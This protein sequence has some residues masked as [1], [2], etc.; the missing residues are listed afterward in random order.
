MN[1]H[2]RH[3]LVVLVLVGYLAAC[4]SSGSLEAQGAQP[5]LFRSRRW[6]DS[7][8]TAT[9]RAAAAAR[10]ATKEAL[11]A[12]A[13]S[14]RERLSTGDFYPGDRIV[15]ELYGGEEVFRDTLAVR[16]G[17]ELFI[18]RFPALSVKGVLRSELDSALTVQLRRYLTQPT[19]R[20]TPLV[21]V[22]VTGGIGRPG[23]VTVRGDAS[24]TDVIT[25]AGGL[26]PLG[27]V[28]KSQVRRGDDRV[29]EPDSMQVVLQTGMTVDQADIRAGDEM[30]I[31]EKR[32]TN[33]LNLAF[34]VSIL[35]GTVT[36][37]IALIRN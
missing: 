6:L 37:I 4:A 13:R 26:T 17:Q 36:S 27:L 20:T 22:L 9:E 30:R 7:V 28:K 35:I 16:A 3:R 11:E 31:G 14:M 23:Y 5:S 2:A 12:D 24:V 25:I 34:T 32:Q 1:S 8:A 10:G 21:R 18:G 29:I 15:I 19:V 33:W